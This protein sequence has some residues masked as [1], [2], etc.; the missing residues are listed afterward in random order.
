MNIYLIL[1][2]AILIGDYLLN[3]FAEILNAR[4]ISNSLPEEFKGYYDEGLY[5]KSQDYL[6]ENT[7][8]RIVKKAVFTA[9]LLIL[10]L[11]GG[12]NFIDI[13][14]RKATDI[15]LFQGLIFFT[16]FFL[17]AEFL[18]VPFS[19]YRTFNIEEKYGFNKTTPK[20]FVS[21]LIKRWL[22]TAL[23]GGAVL[24][25]I[26][27]FFRNLG[28][29]A[30]V[31]CWL[32][33]ICFEIF[34]TFLA[35]VLIMPLFNKFVP[36]EKDE[37]AEKIY[38]YARGENF[39][40]KSIL[41]MDGS[42][43]STKSNAFFTGFG[44]NRR[45]ALFDTLLKRHSDEE[46]VSVLAHE[47]GH[48]KKAHIIKLMI[49]SFLTTGVM[50]YTFSLFLNNPLLFDAFK[51]ERTS[52]HASLILVAIL[53]L[54]LGTVFSIFANALSR[55]YEYQADYYACKTYKKPLS[56]INAL[57]RLSADNLSNLTPHRFKVI[58][59]Y[60]HP[61]VLKRIEAIKKNFFSS[62]SDHE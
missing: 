61:P 34:V 35:P 59:N 26:L 3:L 14:A 44:K 2:P 38:A 62:N 19:V 51:M 60:S 43:R 13:I 33:V 55:K 29:G 17:I 5:R 41:K 42:R 32:A 56:M 40:L 28:P 49:V 47:I 58:L 30:W 54:P 27:W 9:I 8:F 15:S 23:L 18:E 7:Y 52:V 45:I 50:F 10:I 21:D 31:W 57:K 36:L 12:F 11:S 6:K 20:T 24:L 53:Y 39:H 22:L 16:V 25:F 37:L 46:L 48:F 4:N 1:I